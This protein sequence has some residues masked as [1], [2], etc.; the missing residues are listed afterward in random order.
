[1]SLDP[2]FDPTHWGLP[3]APQRTWS[4]CDE[5]ATRALG[6]AL[7]S[8]LRPGDFLGLTGTLG[9]CK[10]TLMQGVVAAFFFFF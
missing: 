8:W 1:M 7:G 6:H 3:D 4:L 9:A 10:T 5:R 2:D